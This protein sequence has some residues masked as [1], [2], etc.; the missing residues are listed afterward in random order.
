MLKRENE[1][2][3]WELQSDSQEAAVTGRKEIR[4]K[5]T[6]YLAT[7]QPDNLKQSLSDFLLLSAVLSSLSV[8][9][10]FAE[11]FPVYVVSVPKVP[12]CAVTVW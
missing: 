11:Q 1:S 9:Y 5:K 6:P 3:R 10:S 7:R 4:G 2:D 12:F 8:C